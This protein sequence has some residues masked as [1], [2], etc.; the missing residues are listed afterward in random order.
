M[1]ARSFRRPVLL[2]CPFLLLCVG[3][4]SATPPENAVTWGLKAATGRLTETTPREWQAVADRIDERT[5]QVEVSL[6][7]AQATAIVDFLQANDLG[8]IQ[9]IV[10]TV[11]GVQNDPNSLGDIEIPQS[12]MDLFGNTAIDFEGAVDDILGE[13]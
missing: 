9:D 1:D 4:P 13:Q 3:C 2:A 5:P 10:D 12:V 8:S 11:E 7:D 6:T